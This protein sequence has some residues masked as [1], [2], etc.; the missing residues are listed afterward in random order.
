M[1]SPLSAVLV[2]TGDWAR[3]SLAPALVALSCTQQQQDDGAATVT[4]AACVGIDEAQ[5]ASFA[6]DLGIPVTATSLAALPSSVAIDLVVISTP[7]SHHGAAI[8]EAIAAGA[9]AI[10]CEKPLANSPTEADR[11]LELTQGSGVPCTV[12]FAFRYSDAVQKLRSAVDSGVVGKIWLIE[13]HEMNSQFHPTAG[14]AMTWKGDPEHAAGGAVFEYGAH[15]LDL[16]CWLVG[17][18]VDIASCFKT[19]IAAGPLDDIAALTMRHAS[20]AIG[21]HISSWVLAGGFPGI[22]V[23]LHGSA[24]TAEI[25][26]D[27]GREP[28]GDVYRLRGLDGVAVEEIR[29]KPQASDV[30]VQRQLAD[31]IATTTAATAAISSSGG[32]AAVDGDSAVGGGGGRVGASSLPSVADAAHVQ[33]VLGAA[34]EATTSRVALL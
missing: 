9:R 28:K 23:T 31:L 18:V 6:A 11:L 15:I 25:T 16:A 26:L 2:G 8:R 33:H 27:T 4:I 10:Y 13:C 7:D 17:P 34:L 22:R 20:G 30:V 32:S 21:T 19:D 12:G 24:G 1:A 14:R 29:F 3:K 5:T